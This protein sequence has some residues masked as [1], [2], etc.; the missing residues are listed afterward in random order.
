MAAQEL[1]LERVRPVP[2]R[3]PPQLDEQAPVLLA[4][5][6]PVDALLLCAVLGLVAIGTV[7]VFSS[8]AVY[9]LKKMGDAGFFL[10]RQLAWL[11]LG[12]VAMWVG[13][14]TDHR[15]LRR[16]AHLLL[17]AAIGSLVAVLFV[18]TTINAARRWFV[19]GPLS[20][21][22]VEAAKLALVAYLAHSLTRK[23]D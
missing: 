3:R 17:F 22:P 5:E 9:G 1:R 15:W 14:A 16:N 12:M 8:S 7:E 18:G 11:G 20:I 6:R 21:Q 2:Q 10:K 4:P 23:A 19:V 13:A